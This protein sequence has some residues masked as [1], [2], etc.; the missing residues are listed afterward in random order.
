MF[1][2]GMYESAVADRPEKEGEGQLVPQNA[3]AK[4][5]ML[6]ANGRG[7]TKT[8]LVESRAMFMEC[9]LAV[10]AAAR[11][12]SVEYRSPRAWPSVAIL[13]TW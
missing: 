7:R 3:D 8:D 12:N 9:D 6:K 4:I 1:S 5:D 10:K 13:P 2:F 11:R